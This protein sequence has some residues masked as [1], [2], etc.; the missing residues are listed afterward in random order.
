MF[1]YQLKFHLHTTS[2]IKTVPASQG[3][4]LFPTIMILPAETRLLECNPLIH[5]IDWERQLPQS[6]LDGPQKDQVA[7][8][9]R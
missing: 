5:S 1:N 8:L 4:I 6:E 3:N 9:R 7:G 2:K